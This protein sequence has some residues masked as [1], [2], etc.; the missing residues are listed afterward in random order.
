MNLTFLPA[1]SFINTAKFRMAIKA[2]EVSGGY[3]SENWV[4]SREVLRNMW[5]L[6]GA[7]FNSQQI[8]DLTVE[9]NK[10]EEHMKEPFTFSKNK[11]K[12]L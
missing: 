6:R 12:I 3:A 7:I 11:F 2:V 9:N 8:S 4:G 10:G 5:W 1:C